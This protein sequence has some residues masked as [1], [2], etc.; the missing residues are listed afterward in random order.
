MRIAHEYIETHF[1]ALESGAM[2]DVQK[3]LGNE[4]M[5]TDLNV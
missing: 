4:P 1:D 2:V 3:I 5:T